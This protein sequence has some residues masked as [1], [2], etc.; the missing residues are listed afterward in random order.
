MKSKDLHGRQLNVYMR[1]SDVVDKLRWCATYDSHTCIECAARDGKTWTND[2]DHTPIGHAIPFRNPPLHGKCRC[3]LLP[4]AKPIPGLELPVGQRASDIGPI[5]A[6]T[7]M[8]DFIKMRGQ[9]FADR[10]LG[11]ERAQL[12][13]SGKLSLDDMLDARGKVMTLREIK[14]KYGL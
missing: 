5:S 10:L 13:M 6:D 2:A 11:I 8:A 1:N 4:V 14:A 3:I 12:F 9:A 7:S